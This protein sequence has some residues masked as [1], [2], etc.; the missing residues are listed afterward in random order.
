MDNMFVKQEVYSELE[1]AVAGTATGSPTEVN[2]AHE[3]DNE[4]RDLSA[5]VFETQRIQRVMQ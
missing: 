2:L 1:V 5:L 3:Q 4:P